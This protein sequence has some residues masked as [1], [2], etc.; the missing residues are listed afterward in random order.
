MNADSISAPEG[1]TTLSTKDDAAIIAAFARRAAAFAELGGLPDPATTGSGT[2]EQTTLWSV[3]DVAEAEICTGIATTARGAE[4]QL[5]TAATY[6]F[7]TAEDEGPCYRADLD[8][9]TA[10][11]DRRDWKDRLVMSALRSLHAQ[12]EAQ[13][14]F[15]GE[16][17]AA[18]TADGGSVVIDGD[19]KAQIGW[20]VYDLSP[21]YQAPDPAWPDT[22]R[23]NM[24]LHA[25]AH[26]DATMKARYEAIKMHPGG[27]DALKAHMRA[28]GIRV[29]V[30]KGPDQ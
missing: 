15:I 2:D 21:A 22:V 30:S 12:K 7:D 19:G 6:L 13:S 1:A 18:W 29:A 26:H 17:L 4:L 25:Q 3:I 14:A 10:Q 9:F 16:W 20:T 24:F 11:G 8:H 23:D 28:K 27:I 5:W